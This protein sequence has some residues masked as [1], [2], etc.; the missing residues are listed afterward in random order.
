MKMQEVRAMAK[1]LGINSY[2][3]T[4]KDLIH[5]IQRAEG[6]YDC[7]GSAGEYC[8]QQECCFRA[9]CLNEKERS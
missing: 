6:N 4:K 7:F 8:D 9:A 2:G 1:V 3:K 5:Q